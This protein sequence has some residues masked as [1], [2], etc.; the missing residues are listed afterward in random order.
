MAGPMDFQYENRFGRVDENSPFITNTAKKRQRSIFDSPSKNTGFDTPN[1]PHLR[2]PHNETFLFNQTSAAKPLPAV[3]SHITNSRAWEPRTPSASIYDSSDAGTP[4]TPAQNDDSEAPTPEQPLGKMIGKAS[5]GD[6][7]P[8]KRRES[9]FTRFTSRVFTSSSPSPDKPQKSHYSRKGEN[10]VHKRRTKNKQ[11]ARRDGDDSDCDTPQNKSSEKSADGKPGFGTHLGS[12]FSWVDRHPN[13]PQTLSFWLQLSVNG[14]LV[15][16]F[17]YI[18]YQMYSSVVGDINVEA[19]KHMSEVLIQIADCSKKYSENNCDPRTRPP[20]LNDL[21]NN[22]AAC[23]NRDAKKVARASVSAKTF[24]MIFNAFVEEFSYKSMIFTGILIFGGF[25][26]SNWAFG[27]MRHNNQHAPPQDH[28]SFYPPATPQRHPSGG[29]LDYNQQ[30]WNQNQNQNMGWPTTT[31][32]GSMNAGMLAAQASQS[33]P[34]LM[35]AEED[36][37]KGEA[38]RSLR[39]RSPRKREL[40][41]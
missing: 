41:R 31:P 11:L 18:I 4:N 20:A 12:F 37:K 16:F 40:F 9:L 21:C 26:L 29:F 2:D 13:L 32:Y 39:E 7:S 1:R 35:P 5:R 24:A 34:A 38:G 17:F 22:W 30:S 23:M 25:N 36:G 19:G 27:L 28:S 14:G 15:F 6:K 10:R 33:M 8:T 3:P